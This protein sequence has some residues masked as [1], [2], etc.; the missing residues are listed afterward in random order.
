[1]DTAKNQPHLPDLARSLGA[2]FKDRARAHDLEGRFVA[3]NYRELKEHRVMSAAVPTELGGGGASHAEISDFIR[4]LAQSCGSTAL[5]LSMHTHLVAAAVW[6]FRHGQP[7]EALL[8]KVAASELVLVSTGAGD[9]IDSVGS[10]ERVSNGYRVS[11]LKRFASGSP[12]GDLAITSVPFE[13]AEAAEVLHFAIPMRAEGVTL[14]EDWDTLGMRGTGSHS[15]ELK[16]VFVPEESV[17]LRRPRGQWHPS[18]N[19]VLTVAAPIYM[20][21][22]VGIAER[23]G[24]LAREA[25]ASRAADATLLQSLGEVEN[26]LATARM[27]F[28]DLLDNTNDYDFE[29]VVERANRALISKTITT[30]AALTTVAKALEVVGGSGLYRC[31]ELER[32]L[33]DIQGAPFHPLPEKKQLAFSARV[34]LGLSPIG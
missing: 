2:R 1:M 21:P 19:V 9:W 28:K 25:A 7:A 18:W 30:K 20:A 17:S 5:A 13:G 3:D 22:Y 32:L 24:Q 27:A 23:A 29:P 8:R 33:R 4:V 10:A 34:A 14:R 26:A 12:V 16:D 6:R 15:L 11:A 31:H